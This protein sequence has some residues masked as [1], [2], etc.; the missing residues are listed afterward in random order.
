MAASGKSSA[1]QARRSSAISGASPAFGPAL[2]G[3][4]FETLPPLAISLNWFKFLKSVGLRS[5]V[6][7]LESIPFHSGWDLVVWKRSLS[8][9]ES[10]FSEILEICEEVELEDS[11]EVFGP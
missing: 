5:V 2:P 8:G 1:L 10:E 3:T 11:I 4:G 6:L 9:L 7:G